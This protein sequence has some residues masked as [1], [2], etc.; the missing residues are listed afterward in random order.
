MGRPGIR[1]SEI[2]QTEKD[3]CCMISHI[4]GFYKIQQTIEYNKKETRLTDI[5][6]K[7]KMSGCQS[8][9][10]GGNRRY[11]GRGL[12]VQTIRQKRSYKD[13]LC[14]MEDITTIL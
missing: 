10:G 4:C 9:E 12:K 13:I 8:G 11:R 5:K 14:Y 2:G 1:L 7:K 6:K 3:K